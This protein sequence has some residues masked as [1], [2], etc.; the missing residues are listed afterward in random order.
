MQ[1]HRGEE[2]FTLIELMVV[3]AIIGILAA[4]AIPAYQGYVVRSQ[5][6]EGL[7]L[8]LRS[9]TAVSEFFSHYGHFPAT[10]ASAGLANAASIVGKYTTQVDVSTSPGVIE[11]T[12]GGQ[13][14]SNLI[15]KTLLLSAVT[16]SGSVEWTC[17]STTIANRYLPSSCR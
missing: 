1:S 4:V 8:T 14:N 5:V 12:Y 11:I 13:A 9:K 10:N 2:G 16:T 3:V 7:E 17:K 6:A 15:G